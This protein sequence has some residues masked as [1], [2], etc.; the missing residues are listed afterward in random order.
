MRK[1][2]EEKNVNLADNKH[3]PKALMDT[4]EA[5]EWTISKLSTTGLK[6]LTRYPGIGA[7]I[8]KRIIEE[9]REMMNEV[10]REEITAA[11]G[12]KGAREMDPDF[13][14]G[15]QPPHGEEPPLM[16]V[17]VRRIREANK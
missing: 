10:A 11:E 2:R 13:L 14:V 4:L 9:S 12:I 5:D 8:A 6:Q 7:V 3:I 17:R 16:S 15:L 1:S